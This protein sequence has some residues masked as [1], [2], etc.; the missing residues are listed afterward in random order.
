MNP[1]TLDF[2]DQF[3]TE[4]LLIRAPRIGDSAIVNRAICESL[5]ELRPWMSWAQ[6]EPTP[7]ESEATVRRALS[8]WAARTELMFLILDKS[9]E[10]VGSSG[11]YR[12]DWSVPK[13]E[14]AYWRRSDCGGH[15]LMTEAVRGIADFAFETLSAERVEIRC[16]TS[17]L[18]SVALARRAGFIAEATLK[19]SLRRAGILHDTLIFARLR[20]EKR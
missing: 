3:E 9:G 14:I 8:E 11:L 7:D 18:K 1:M 17:N 2:P 19:N 5:L 12:I 4:R 6:T 16:A 10:M 13:F 20:E 15:G